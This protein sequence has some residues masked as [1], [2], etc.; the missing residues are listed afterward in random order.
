MSALSRVARVVSDLAHVNRRFL[1]SPG[2]RRAAM[3]ALAT[4]STPLELSAA[5][6]R[7]RDAAPDAARPYVGLSGAAL[8]FAS[9]VRDDAEAP[10][11][12]LV[13][14]ELDPQRIFAG[15]HTALR[16]ADRLAERL[17]MP[18]QV[19]VLSEAITARRRGALLH[20]VT[21]RL[22]RDPSRTSVLTRD[23]LVGATAHPRDVWVATH[24]TTAHPLQV[25]AHAGVLD[26]HRVVYL[27]QDHE[28]GFAALSTDRLMASGTYRAGF[29]LLVNSAPVAAV[30][31]LIE[32]VDVDADAVF[33]PELDLD[34]LAAVAERRTARERCAASATVFFY[35]RPS[36]PRNLFPLGVA[37]LRV[38]ARALPD[39]AVRWVSAGEPHR[40]IDLGN[41]HLLESLGT[42]DWPQ[43]FDLLSTTDVVLSLQASPHPSHPPL[44]AALVG[45]TSITNEVAATR[46]SVHPL[47]V[48]VDADP[49][50]LGLAVASAV[51]QATSEHSTTSVDAPAA[52]SLTS[53][54][55]TLDAAVRFVVEQLNPRE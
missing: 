21:D 27:V 55:G 24:W 3:T 11:V 49:G 41:G 45:A 30:L 37:S 15:V 51:R 42:L 20:A 54:G 23:G 18:L 6:I 10:S 43:Y 9:I 32:G 52:G 2:F 53:L 38:A 47:L 34:R 5:T 28:P 26:P 33:A 35:G 8:A 1:L 17:G 40:A 39:M 4:P 14:S 46:A 25:A 36:K 31:G 50:A 7:E 19:I 12:R 13:L 16:V 29:Q 44:E 48:A 22:R